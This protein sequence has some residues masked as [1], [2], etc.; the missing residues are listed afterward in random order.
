MG[1]QGREQGQALAPQL[2]ADGE[3]RAGGKLSSS[4]SRPFWAEG[5]CRHRQSKRRHFPH[6]E[7]EEKQ[8]FPRKDSGHG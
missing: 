2:R 5:T 1:E 6:G 4:A 7:R 3:P 8:R